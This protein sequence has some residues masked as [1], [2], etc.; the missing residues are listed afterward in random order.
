MKVSNTP[1]SNFKDSDYSDEQY[2]R[3]CLLDRGPSAGSAKQRYSIP[4]REPDGTLNRNACHAAA[5]VLS[6]TGGS[7]SARGNKVKASPEQIASA[8]SKLL[9]LYKAL[10]EEPPDGLKHIAMGEEFLAHYGVL[11]MKWGQ[12]RERMRSLNATKAATAEAKNLRGRSPAPIRVQPTIGKTGFSKTRVDTIGGEDHPAH[13]DAIDAAI[14]RQKLAKSGH[15]ALSNQELRDLST[16]LQLE[17]QVT[18]LTKSKGRHFVTKAF[19]QQQQQ[20][21]SKGVAKGFAKVFSP[22]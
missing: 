4:V 5:A 6:S 22:A 20:A 15:A 16:R 2:A 10:G 1:W 8:R 9:A 19:E 18:M 21:I 14:S 11:G 17:N 3:A 13:K 12:H 7:G